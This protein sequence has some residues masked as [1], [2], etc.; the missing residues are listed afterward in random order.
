MVAIRAQ[1]IADVIAVHLETLI[2]EGAL[3]PGE[4]LASE[5]DLA[6]KLDVSRPRCAKP[7]TSS[8]IGASSPR[9]AAA[10]S[11]RSS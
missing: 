3:R 5:R 4:K 8:P 1:K 7:S 9:R 10:P 11:W 6:V 2:R